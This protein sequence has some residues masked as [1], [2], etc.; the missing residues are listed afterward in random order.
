MTWLSLA[1]ELTFNI[2]EDLFE[3]LAFEFDSEA[4]EALRQLALFDVYINQ[5]N[6]YTANITDLTTFDVYI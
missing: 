3:G 4:L 2:G 6:I 5:N 1:K